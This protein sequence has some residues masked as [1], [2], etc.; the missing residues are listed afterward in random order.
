MCVVAPDK[1]KLRWSTI[2]LKNDVVGILPKLWERNVAKHSY[3]AIASHAFVLNYMRAINT[4]FRLVEPYCNQFL[5]NELPPI[6]LME[7]PSVGL[8]SSA[9]SHHLTEKA[10]LMG[11]NIIFLIFHIILK[12]WKTVLRIMGSKVFVLIDAYTANFQLIRKNT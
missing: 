8:G 12:F 6:R 10:V 1:I 5:R 11:A 4:L 3:I 7:P 2:L 9:R